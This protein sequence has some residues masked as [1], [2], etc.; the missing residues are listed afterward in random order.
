MIDWFLETETRKNLLMYNSSMDA[1]VSIIV[2]V[3]NNKNYVNK[4]FDSLLNQTHE[5]LEIILVDDG[6]NDGSEKI[7]DDYTKKDTRIK[8]IRQQNAGQSA[9]RNAGMRLASGKFIGFI[10]SDDE[11][12]PTFVEDLLNAFT[13]DVALTVCGMNYKRLKQKTANDVYTNPLRA[14]KKHE[15]KKAYILY[16]LA[17]DGRMYSSVNK[18]YR[19]EIAKQCSFDES[20]NFAEDTKF[21]L[22]YIQKAQGLPAFV[23]KPLYIYNFGTDGSTIRST[24]VKWKNWKTSYKNLK[25]WLGSNP[26]I[27]EKFW[28]RAVYARWRISHI[29]SKK[30]AKNS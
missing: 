22:D 12:A 30:R 3:Y 4:C 20:L 2:P 13:E 28:L 10:D 6:S 11:I 14:C 27:R 21:V 15:T 1:K 8:S 25:A 23:L 18:L 9:A 17:T 7:V 29:R 24:A 19:T 16:L 5:N 26:T